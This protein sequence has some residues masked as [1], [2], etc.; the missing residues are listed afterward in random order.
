[1]CGASETWRELFCTLPVQ[2]GVGAAP[3]HAKDPHG[4]AHSPPRFHNGTLLDRREHRY[5]AHLELRGLHP[6]QAGTYHCK[7]WNDAGSVRSG[8][9]GL[10]VLGEHPALSPS[11]SQLNPKWSPRVK[12]TLD[13]AESHP[14]LPLNP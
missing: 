12:L 7:A 4:I 2:G 10:I 6:D 11:K 3:P 1:M 5:G 8:A 14:K 13:L 9:A